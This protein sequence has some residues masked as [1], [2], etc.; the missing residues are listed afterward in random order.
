MWGDGCL[1]ILI[2]SKQHFTFLSMK[3]CGI[4]SCVGPGILSGAGVSTVW[5]HGET[6][7]WETRVSPEKCGW[8]KS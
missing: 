3:I 7:C 8:C 1:A 5:Y 4:C 6:T 2:S